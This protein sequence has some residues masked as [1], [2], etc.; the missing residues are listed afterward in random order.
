MAIF[1]SKTKVKLEIVKDM[2]NL[3]KYIPPAGFMGTIR[4]CNSDTKKQTDS[5][6]IVSEG[7]ALDISAINSLDMATIDKAFEDHVRKSPGIRALSNFG[8]SKRNVFY[9][10]IWLPDSVVRNYV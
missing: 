2:P 4:L 1:D 9:S 7:S 10:A 3:E 5:W 6:L 8:P